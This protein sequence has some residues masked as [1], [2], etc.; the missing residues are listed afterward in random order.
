MQ[1]INKGMVLILIIAS[2]VIFSAICWHSIEE[3][4]YLKS[5]FPKSFTV[6]EAMFAS[7]IELMKIIILGIPFFLVI[8][9]GVLWLRS[10]HKNAL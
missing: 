1:H 7:V 10:N 8:G 9:L 4:H 2:A 5:F 6:E 3:I